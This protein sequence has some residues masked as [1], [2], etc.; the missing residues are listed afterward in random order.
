MPYL[1]ETPPRKKKNRT[2]QKTSSLKISTERKKGNSPIGE[3][4]QAESIHSNLL[5]LLGILPL[6]F[7][8]TTGSRASVFK[9]Y[10][11]EVGG[12]QKKSKRSMRLCILTVKTQCSIRPQKFSSINIWS[13]EKKNFKLR[14]LFSCCRGMFN[15]SYLHQPSG[16]FQVTQSTNIQGVL[17]PGWHYL[18]A[19]A[20]SG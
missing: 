11:T 9:N 13:S 17:T 8:S 19:G 6:T 3:C 10:F 16:A 14:A 15:H 5:P 4:G 7:H 18:T 2:K 12:W 20:Q 1:T